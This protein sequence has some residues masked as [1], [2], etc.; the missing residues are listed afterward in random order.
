LFAGQQ[1]RDDGAADRQRQREQNGNRLQERAE[2]QTSTAYTIIRPV[3]IAV[4][5]PCVSSFRLSASPDCLM[6]TP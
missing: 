1:Q 3:L 6:L 2:Q 4:A 5:N